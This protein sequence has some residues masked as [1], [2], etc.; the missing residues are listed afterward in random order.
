MTV[1]IT[2]G[3]FKSNSA[4]SVMELIP[5]NMADKMLADKPNVIYIKITGGNFVSAKGYEQIYVKEA[6][7]RLEISNNYTVKLGK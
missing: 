7:D 1:E 3:T 6:F 5:K 2:G 4:Y